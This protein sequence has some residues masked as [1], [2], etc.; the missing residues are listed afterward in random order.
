MFRYYA[1]CG[2]NGDLNK[3]HE[4]ELDEV[5]P[6]R[7]D[8]SKVCAKKITIGA[9]LNFFGLAKAH[10]EWVKSNLDKSKDKKSTGDYSAAS[11]TGNRSAASNTGKNGIAIAWGMDSKARGALGTYIVCSEWKIKGCE[12][13]L[14]SAKMHKVDGKVIKPNVWYTL[15]DGKFVE[16]DNETD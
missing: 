11:N 2:D 10:I 8:D 3:F 12:R 9:E 5:S 6:Q 1:P 13:V 16:A 4:V 15:K 7:N 14:K